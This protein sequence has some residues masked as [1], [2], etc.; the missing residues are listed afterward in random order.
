[1][2]WRANFCSKRR[3]TQSKFIAIGMLL[4]CL[5]FYLKF[6]SL[7]DSSNAARH[8]QYQQQ[9]PQQHVQRPHSPRL[10]ALEADATDVLDVHQLP[11]GEAGLDQDANATMYEALIAAELRKQHAKL[12]DNGHEVILAGDEARRGAKQ[13]KKIALNEEVSQQLRYNRT[14]PDVRNP[15][16]QKLEYDMDALPTASVIVIFYNEPYSVLLRTV[17]SVI[18]NSDARVL[19]EIILVDDFSDQVSLQGELEY[20]MR[21]RL[22]DLV[23]IVRL[24]SR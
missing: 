11:S 10:F 24:K 2:F 19:K 22:P 8:Q 16:C 21:T 1:M 18:A 5:L 3:I 9:P 17:H 7:Q 4:I 23:K 6:K 12:G 15:L 14:L 13:M 20:Y